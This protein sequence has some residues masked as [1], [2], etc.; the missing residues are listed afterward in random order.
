MITN[1]KQYRI[2]RNKAK[3]FAQAIE[4]FDGAARERLGVDARLV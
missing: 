1:E 2:T 3:G 4:D